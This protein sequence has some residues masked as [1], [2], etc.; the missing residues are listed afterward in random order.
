MVLV[1]ETVA[2]SA[3]VFQDNCRVCEVGYCCK[4]FL[5]LK[6]LP[7]RANST[8]AQLSPQGCILVSVSAAGC[9][10]LTIIFC[11]CVVWLTHYP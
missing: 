9:L 8:Q 1:Y 7:A 5:L 3:Q 6:T 2:R 4:S 11:D 10:L